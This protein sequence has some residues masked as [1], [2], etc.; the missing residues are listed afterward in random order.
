MRQIKEEFRW[1]QSKICDGMSVLEVGAGRGAFA[2]YVRTCRYTGLDR[3]THAREMAERQGIT[4][5]TTSIEAWA[6][7]HREAYDVVCH[8]Q[9]LEHVSH[10]GAF[11]KACARSLKPGGMLLVSVP[12]EDSYLSMACNA[13]LNM[14]PHHITRWLDQALVSVGDVIGCKTV[15]ISHD[16]ISPSHR[17]SQ[18][19][20]AIFRRWFGILPL[21][22]LR[23]STKLKKG[24]NP[25]TSPHFATRT[26]L[27]QK[28]LGY[29]HSVKAVYVKQ[30]TV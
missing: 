26:R 14:P 9:V 27:D 20:E 13:A 23:L 11:L 24:C 15:E 17:T 6:E 3:S 8:F 30:L 21:I 12:S 25:A 1:A 10:P 16:S 18:M 7:D 19:V 4:I 28:A 22:D 29:G 2:R 5:H